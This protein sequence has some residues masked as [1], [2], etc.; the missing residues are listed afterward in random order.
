LRI[1]NLVQ[2]LMYLLTDGELVSDLDQ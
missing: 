1:S 2:H